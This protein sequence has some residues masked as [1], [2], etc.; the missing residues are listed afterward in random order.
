[1]AN[2]S[3]FSGGYHAL[4][5]AYGTPY[6]GAPALQVVSGS[7]GT[8]AYTITCSPQ[9]LKTAAGINIPI[10]VNTPITIGAN[11]AYETVT[12][13]AVSTNNFGQILIT[14]TFTYSHGVG[15]QVRSGTFG[16]QEA[17]Q[18]CVNDANPGG[19]I[20]L[21]PAWFK[22]NGGVTAGRTVITG[23]KSLATAVYTV[24]DW[25]GS[26]GALSYRAASGS[27]LT[28]TAVTLY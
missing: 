2:P 26:T 9:S 27:N 6:S 3:T 14:A 24:L 28:S 25:S 8:G 22:A 1:M 23:T 10:S 15:A 21:S 20:L 7:T 18:Q 16:L 13:T 5:F 4:E 17:A 12:P 11:G 19:L